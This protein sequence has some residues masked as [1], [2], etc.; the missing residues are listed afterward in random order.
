MKLNQDP[1]THLSKAS[2]RII[3]AANQSG[4]SFYTSP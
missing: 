3:G 4:L 1:V 2:K